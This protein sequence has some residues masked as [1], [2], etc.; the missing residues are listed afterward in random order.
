MKQNLK[1]GGLKKANRAVKTIAQQEGTS[2]D[3]VR[4]EIKAAISEAMQNPDPKIRA[5]W[6][7]IP[8]K[9]EQPE[10]EELIAWIAAQVAARR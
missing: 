2:V 5:M 4:S 9:G 3:S 7:N 1:T 6:E 10:P 8:C